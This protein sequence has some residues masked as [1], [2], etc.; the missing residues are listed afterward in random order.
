MLRGKGRGRRRRMLIFNFAVLLV[1]LCHCVADES[2]SKVLELTEK[3]YDEVINNTPLILVE[4]YAPWYA[5]LIPLLM[6]TL[7]RPQ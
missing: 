7:R 3:N 5:D 2:E 1:V 6:D 4:F